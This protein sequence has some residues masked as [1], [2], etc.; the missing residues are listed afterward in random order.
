MPEGGEKSSLANPDVDLCNINVNDFTKLL[1]LINLADERHFTALHMQ[2][3]SFPSRWIFFLLS[4][5]HF[6]ELQRMIGIF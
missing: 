4:N 5:Y 6:L 3:V 1:T 2:R